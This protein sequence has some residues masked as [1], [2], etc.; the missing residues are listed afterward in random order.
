MSVRRVGMVG[1]V[2]FDETV[3]EIADASTD[4]IV[5]RLPNGVEH[6]FIPDGPLPTVDQD[7]AG[8]W[9]DSGTLSKNQTGL[10]SWK[11]AHIQEAVTGFASGDPG[12]P[13]EGEP[14]PQ[15]DP[16]VHSLSERIRAKA[17]E[18]PYDERTLY[19]WKKKIPEGAGA[20]IDGRSM[21]S[22]TGVDMPEEVKQAVAEVAEEYAE[23]SDLTNDQF[24]FLVVKHMGDTELPD[25]SLA[26]LNR[27]LAQV[28]V[29]DGLDRN[30][31]SRREFVKSPRD[32]LGHLHSDRPGEVIVIDTTRVDLHALDPVSLE[33][34]Q[35]DLTVAMDLYTR[36]IVSFRFTPTTKGVDLALLL[37]DIVS[38]APVDE[39]WPTDIPYPYCG[40]PETVILREFDLP[41][42]TPLK[43]RPTVK[44]ETILVD[45]GLN[46]QSF[47][48]T[49]GCAKVGAHIQ[50]ARP[51]RPT[52]KGWVERLFETANQQL[53]MGLPGYTGPN[54]LARGEKPEDKAV[55]FIWELEQIFGR[56][57]AEIY[58]ERPHDALRPVECPRYP[59][60]PNQAYE[61]GIA[62]S[63]FVKVPSDP[64][65]NLH[66][67]PVIF[68]HIRN[69]GISHR[70]LDFDDP[71]LNQFRYM[72]SPHPENK[73]PFRCDPRDLRKVWFE[74][75]N[76]G[77]WHEIYWRF[78]REI[79]RPLSE[80]SLSF[81]KR[82]LRSGK[83]PP[84]QKRLRQRLLDF[85]LD[86]EDEILVRE[87]RLL[88]REVMRA[89]STERQ[90]RGPL[91]APVLPDLP[92]F[93]ES[94]WTTEIAE[95]GLRN[96]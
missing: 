40:V 51:K 14:R 92:E 4:G 6:R 36:S 27:Y 55:F 30:A 81:V 89:T 52:D 86:L 34:A 45:R 69:D 10:A 57:I 13:R 58:Q 63:G 7:P 1:K 31:K 70:S 21:K 19:N 25:K 79:Q 49:T 67:L 48:F 68:K 22:K 54:V 18:I 65:F 2:W 56:W 73:W 32:D 9:L 12:A 71:I 8:T 91:P 3:A 41:T 95:L 29:R 59:L 60:T 77:E 11:L 43:P 42:G 23:S 85:Q 26:T 16:T 88:R 5:V 39:R 33:W 17:E 35:L 47:A 50:S 44:P 93:V 62:R 46:Y 96:D 38:P 15:Y 94:S 80:E 66:L 28:G 82:E 87:D 53:F 83:R 20:F 74:H 37:S 84:T 64:N 24:W 72:P 78:G 61:E 76:T 75:P 90:V